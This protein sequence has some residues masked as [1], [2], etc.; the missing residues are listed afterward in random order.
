MSIE[1]ESSSQAVNEYLF[2]PEQKDAILRVTTNPRLK[3]ELDVITFPPSKHDD[4]RQSISTPFKK[5]SSIGIGVLD[6]L[7]TELIYLV[8]LS[9]DLLS[10]F[11]LRQ[12]NHRARTLVDSLYEYGV[13]ARHSLDAFCALLQTK[14][15]SVVPLNELYAELCTRECCCCGE[16]GSLIFLPNWSRCCYKCLGSC[17]QFEMQTMSSVRKQYKLNRA[18]SRRL[19]AL[20]TLPGMY[21]LSEKPWKARNV[22]VQTKQAEKLHRQYSLSHCEIQKREFWTTYDEKY[23]CMAACEFP[24][25]DSKAKEVD[26][27]VWCAGCQVAFERGISPEALHGDISDELNE[28]F[29]RCKTM[30]FRPEF[31]EHFKRCEQAQLLWRTSDE[32]DIDPAV[33]YILV[34]DGTQQTARDGSLYLLD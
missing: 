10:I 28:L 2:P 3:Y 33:V 18:A 32:G 15:A 21:G 22:L 5:V 4:V 24:H 20:K 30:H 7:P 1:K 6:Q 26:E 23:R 27:P 14:V 12:V 11:K 25:Y 8:L 16:F 34:R 9:L 31:L 17:R 29:S 13:V 19:V